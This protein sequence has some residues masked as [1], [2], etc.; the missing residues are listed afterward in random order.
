ME[1]SILMKRF[2]AMTEVFKDERTRWLVGKSK[3]IIDEEKMKPDEYNSLMEEIMKTEME[4]KMIINELKNSPLTIS[5]IA[6]RINIAPK[7]V[8]THLK[9]L[10]HNNTVSVSGEK[11]GE[12]EFKLL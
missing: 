4:R 2:D 7:T 9:T 5:N 1:K 10:K 3:A 8:F 11:N 12:L 6:K